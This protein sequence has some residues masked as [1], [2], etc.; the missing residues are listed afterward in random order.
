MQG[1]QQGYPWKC[2]VL[3]A[4]NDPIST[5][6]RGIW[7]FWKAYDQLRC[8]IGKRASLTHNLCLVFVSVQVDEN[9]DDVVPAKWIERRRGRNSDSDFDHL[10]CAQRLKSWTEKTASPPSAPPSN[11]SG[12]MQVDATNTNN[13]LLNMQVLYKEKECSCS[14]SVNHNDQRE[15]VILVSIQC[16]YWPACWRARRPAGTTHLEW[17]LPVTRPCHAVDWSLGVA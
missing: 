12:V 13:I 11:R 8:T 5:I 3:F 2:L 17:R 15:W 6:Q 16:P 10:L 4:K 14:T 9:N 7:A 1:G